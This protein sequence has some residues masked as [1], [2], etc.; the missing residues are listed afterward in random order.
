MAFSMS[1]PRTSNQLCLFKLDGTFKLSSVQPSSGCHFGSGSGRDGREVEL[2]AQ[3]RP[4]GVLLDLVI[5]LENAL[6]VLSHTF[7]QT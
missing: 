4:G 2:P 7:A 3:A 1:L 6:S 5:E